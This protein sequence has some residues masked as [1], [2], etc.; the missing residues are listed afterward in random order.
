MRL[1]RA[2]DKLE[3]ALGTCGLV[4][5]LEKNVVKAGGLNLNAPENDNSRRSCDGVTSKDASKDEASDVILNNEMKMKDDEIFYLRTQLNQ[6]KNQKHA[7]EKEHTVIAAQL[8]DTRGQALQLGKALSENARTTAEAELAATSKQLEDVEALYESSIADAAIMGKQVIE[9]EASSLA[10][11]AKLLAKSKQVQELEV[12]VTLLTERSNTAEKE[13]I[14]AQNGKIA[15]EEKSE[16]LNND[17]IVEKQRALELE[18]ALEKERKAHEITTSEKATLS[19]K[20]TEVKSVGDSAAADVLVLRKDLQMAKEKN[21]QLTEN[22][23]LLTDEKATLVERSNAKEKE[24]ISVQD[25]EGALIIAKAEQAA[26]LKELHDVKESALSCATNL[27]MK[28]K[29]MEALKTENVQLADRVHAVDN[30]LANSKTQGE[31]CTVSMAAAERKVAGAD[32][33]K[34]AAQDFSQTY[35]HNFMIKAIDWFVMI[36]FV[37]HVLSRL[38]TWKVKLHGSGVLVKTVHYFSGKPFDH[39]SL[40]TNCATLEGCK[41]EFENCCAELNGRCRNLRKG[42]DTSETRCATLQGNCTALEASNAALHSQIIELGTYTVQFF[43]LQ[44]GRLEKKNVLPR[45]EEENK[46]LAQEKIQLHAQIQKLLDDNTNLRSN[47]RKNLR[48][49]FNDTVSQDEEFRHLLYDNADLEDKIR[50]LENEVKHLRSKPCNCKQPQIEEAKVQESKV[51]ESKVQECK[52]EERKADPR[53]QF[54]EESAQPEDFVEL[55]QEYAR[56]L[57]AKCQRQSS[58]IESL[59]K[60][61]SAALASQHQEENSGKAKGKSTKEE[62]NPHAEFIQELQER[63]ATLEKEKLVL[64]EQN[65]LLIEELKAMGGAYKQE[66]EGSDDSSVE[67]VNER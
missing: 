10:N 47:L 58:D 48:G 4:D 54:K 41:A 22:N 19:V 59:N 51:Q 31:K 53:E 65:D 38:L 36:C 49:W 30:E 15:A 7:V 35:K 3:H 12:T 24:V 11:N 9:L 52:E 50:A 64:K 27:V 29:R 1:E 25:L 26:T 57:E 21:I 17:L 23:I 18:A 42:C 67:D 39:E 28:D 33:E 62:E 63:S 16:A 40:K 45:E 55:L 60:S 2:S 32:I 20:L 37:L 13:A 46:K 5:K 66:E 8:N 6:S 61:L 43:A 56:G 14:R 34:A 44:R